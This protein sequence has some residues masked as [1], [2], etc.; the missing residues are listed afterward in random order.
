MCVVWWSCLN[1]YNLISI[2]LVTSTNANC[3]NVVEHFIKEAGCN[4]FQYQ[5]KTNVTFPWALLCSYFLWHL[6]AGDLIYCTRYNMH[7]VVYMREKWWVKTHC[8]AVSLEEII[9]MYDNCG[10]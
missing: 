1:T 4:L 10:F 3:K 8:L 6:V 5:I 7:R 2:Y 9:K